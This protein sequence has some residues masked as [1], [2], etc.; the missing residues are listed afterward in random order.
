MDRNENVR[1]L[2]EMILQTPPRVIYGMRT[3]K[4]MFYAGCIAEHLLQQ[5]VILPPAKKQQKGFTAEDAAAV[6]QEYR[7]AKNTTQQTEG[8]TIER[9]NE[10]IEILKLHQDARRELIGPM[11]Y[12]A[13]AVDLPEEDV[14][15][16]F[17]GTG[18]DVVDRAGRVWRNGKVLRGQEAGS[19]G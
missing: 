12:D 8:I 3:G 14:I 15:A 1:R 11:R 13:A 5:G 17:Y 16:Y 18:V 6:M 4:G 19:R 2:T 9:I 10:A 7:T